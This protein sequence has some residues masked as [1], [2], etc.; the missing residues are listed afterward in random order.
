MISTVRM[1]MTSTAT[2]PRYTANLASRWAGVN[3]CHS[4]CLVIEHPLYADGQELGNHDQADDGNEDGAQEV[5]VVALERR[6]ERA[7]DTTRADDAD[8]GGVTDV[9]VELVGG[10]S[11]ESVEHLG[12]DRV[13]EYGHEGRAR[14]LA[15]FH[16]LEGDLLDGLGKEFADEADGR[17]DESQDARHGAE[18]DRLDEQDGEDD[19]V[20]GSADADDDARRPRGPDRHQ[21]AGRQQADGERE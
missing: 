14:R 13:Y 19:R 10:E 3:R 9:G 16:G 4:Y 17:E 8:H 20:E 18:T 1:D 15:C 2:E 21:V 5:V 11:D 12:H 6:E 7:A